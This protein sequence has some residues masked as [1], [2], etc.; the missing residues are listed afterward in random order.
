MRF[1]RTLSPRAA[2]AIA[3]S[4]ALLSAGCE[5]LS[6]KY[7]RFNVK[8]NGRTVQTERF[9]ND[10]IGL[11]PEQGQAYQAAK[12][13]DLEGAVKLLKQALQRN[14]EDEWIWYDLAVIHEARGEWTLAED[15][16]QNAIKWDEDAVRKGRKKA[17]KGKGATSAPQPTKEF[18][19]E[20]AFIQ[21]H[22]ND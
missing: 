14:K 3:F 10:G 21:K 11:V 15:A 1:L 20:L 8:E 12:R 13:G 19:D 2:V 18:R 9:Y 6:L 22:K 17:Q 7:I 4:L 5:A 16:I